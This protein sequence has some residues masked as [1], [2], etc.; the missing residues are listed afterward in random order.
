MTRRLHNF[1]TVV[2]L[3]AAL[4]VA[5]AW[6]RGHFAGDIL[7][8]VTGGTSRPDQTVWAFGNGGGGLALVV[9]HGFA[10]DVHS[11]KHYLPLGLGWRSVESLYA[12]G[13]W[14]EDSPWSGAGFYWIDLDGNSYAGVPDLHGVIA[15]A[16]FLFVL[17]A[18]LP[19]ARAAAKLRR[20]RAPGMCPRCGYDLRATPDKCPE[21]G[22]LP[23]PARGA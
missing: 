4:A 2:S 9:S 12:A 20:R 13:R 14:P 15:P 1:L 10:S 17:A 16:W 18:A 7:R 19:A 11:P 3:L 6:V 22:T 5:A 8:Y 23:G 21:C